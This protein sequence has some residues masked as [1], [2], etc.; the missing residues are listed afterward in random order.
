M[1]KIL[2]VKNFFSAFFD[3]V[4]L[5]KRPT[6][7]ITAN[8]YWYNVRQ[9]QSQKWK[10]KPFD[11]KIAMMRARY[12]TLSRVYCADTRAPRRRC[13]ELSKRYSRL[14]TGWREWCSLQAA[15]YLTINL[16]IIFTVRRS[17]LHG[18]CDRNSVRLS[19]SWTVST[20]FD[21]R[22]WFLHRMVAPSF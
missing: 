1:V 3:L 4:M 13:T 8:N 17:A 9:K 16:S 12:Q 7:L 6:K 21:L 14:S 15:K 10:S 22:S 19:H 18:L 5:R 11:W 2:R 20:W